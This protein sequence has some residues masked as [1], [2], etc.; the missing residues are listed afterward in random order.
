MFV[1]ITTDRS[2]RPNTLGELGIASGSNPIVSLNEYTYKSGTEIFGEKEPA[3]YIY[4][5]KSGAV[6]TYKLLSD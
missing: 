2:N 5:V 6:R 4:Q 1:R 3:E